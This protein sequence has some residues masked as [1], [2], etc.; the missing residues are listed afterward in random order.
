[1]TEQ[2]MCDW[3]GAQIYKGKGWMLNNLNLSSRRT[4]I[5]KECLPLDLQEQQRRDEE[6]A[7]PQR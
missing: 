5:C 2:I 6:A 3:C 1:M 4:H 7:H